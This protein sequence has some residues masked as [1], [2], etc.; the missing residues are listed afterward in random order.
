MSTLELIHVSHR[1][2]GTPAVQDI[3][4]S[5]NAGGRLAIVG[6]SGSGKTTLLRLIAGFE[7]PHEGEITLAGE[8]LVGAG[9][10]V[11]A[12]KR[13]I[14]YLAQD[15]ALFP[16]LSV[17]ANIGFALD[18]DRK[19]KRRQ[20]EALAER[21]S[22]AP[23][24]LSRSPHELS[25]GQQQRVALARALAQQPR[26]M[27]LD[28]P[29]SALDTGLRAAMRDAVAQ[30]LSEAGVTAILVTHDQQEALSFATD[31]AVLRGG[32]LQQIGAPLDLYLR[33]DDEQTATFLGEAL[34]MNA[35]VADGIATCALGTLAVSSSTARGEYSIMLRPEQLRI[36]LA[37]PGG[38]DPSLAQ[39][40][41]VAN[42]LSGSQCR[43]TLELTQPEAAPV[44]L[45]LPMPGAV[46][47]SV[48][49]QVSV[50]VLNTAH[51]M[52]PSG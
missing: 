10:S 7:F 40:R 27:L 39:G 4:F 15:G 19:S 33:P 17:E 21:V 52:G 43:L 34:F 8:R 23:A 45:T 44:R 1:Y 20:V 41:V 24:M 48:G 16:H 30:V 18:G 35:W 22:L 25:G 28:E 11:P 12:H 26:L 50:R 5:L 36:D 51:V 2:N 3:S 31:L 29:F 47:P 6:P 37:P 42:T 13:G 9:G 14:G 32:Q 49:A 38:M 46:A